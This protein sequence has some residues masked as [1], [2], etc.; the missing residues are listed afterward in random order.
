MAMEMI[1]DRRYRLGPIRT[2]LLRGKR[3]NGDIYGRPGSAHESVT[4]LVRR[5]VHRLLI[6]CHLRLHIHLEKSAVTDLLKELEAVVGLDARATPGKV[7]LHTS[8]S[9]RRI[10]ADHWQSFLVPGTDTD[11]HPNMDSVENAQF[12]VALV[13]WYRTHHAEIA[14]AVKD[15][16]RLDWLERFILDGGFAHMYCEGLSVELDHPTWDHV[17]LGYEI[18][19]AIDAAIDAQHNSAREG[20]KS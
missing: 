9:W 20:G 12:V 4:E 14:E 2:R 1:S 13:N 18:R 8:Y 5:E 17:K 6:T 11:R 16:A 7:E 15:K 10:M 19:D 3:N